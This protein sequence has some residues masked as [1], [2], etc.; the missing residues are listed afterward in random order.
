MLIK[1]SKIYILSCW[2]LFH[3]YVRLEERSSMSGTSL[4]IVLRHRHCLR[5]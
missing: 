2:I 4:C 3:C 1:T 5:L